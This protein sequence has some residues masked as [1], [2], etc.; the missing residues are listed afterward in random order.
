MSDHLHPLGKLHRGYTTAKQVCHAIPRIAG[1]TL[2]VFVACAILAWGLL[3]ALRHPQA[4]VIPLAVCGL[5]ALIF[6]RKG[7]GLF[8]DNLP[9]VTPRRINTAPGGSRLAE[10]AELRRGRVIR[11]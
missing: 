1:G 7:L 3:F 8:F 4:W 2:L 5:I 11:G 10:R 9:A 6:A